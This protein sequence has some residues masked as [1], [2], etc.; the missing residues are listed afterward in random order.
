M[1][2]TNFLKLLSVFLL[3]ALIRGVASQSSDCK[4]IFKLNAADP[5]KAESASMNFFLKEEFIFED[6]ELEFVF[7]FFHRPISVRKFALFFD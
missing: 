1:N 2:Q 5:N 6:L 3:A 4:N 7:A